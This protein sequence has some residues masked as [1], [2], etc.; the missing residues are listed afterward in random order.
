MKLNKTT[1]R[2]IINRLHCYNQTNKLH[3]II[4]LESQFDIVKQMS[5]NEKKTVFMFIYS[6]IYQET[7]YI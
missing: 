7:I 6:L 4:W 1:I 5:E 2:A 3:T